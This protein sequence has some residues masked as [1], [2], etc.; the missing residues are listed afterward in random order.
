MQ[1][2]LST[3]EW[4][5]QQGAHIS[6][7]TLQSIKPLLSALVLPTKWACK[8]LKQHLIFSLAVS[9]HPCLLTTLHF[10][11][12][13]PHTKLSW[14]LQIKLYNSCMYH[15]KFLS[16]SA[17][18]FLWKYI[19]EIY[20]KL[21]TLSKNWQIHFKLEGPKCRIKNKNA[22]I[23]MNYCT[24]LFLNIYLRHF[25]HTDIKLHLLR[26]FLKNECDKSVFDWVYHQVF[27]YVFRKL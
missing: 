23:I 25:G 11:R 26:N 6:A 20:Y 21:Q 7:E 13:C 4:H 16:K 2:V 14:T 5:L 17:F 19:T 15:F 18:S 12:L 8:H 22:N 27:P 1:S 10:Y 24:S 3:S 9:I